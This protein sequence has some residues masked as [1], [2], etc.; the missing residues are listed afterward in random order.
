MAEQKEEK[1]GGRCSWDL[2]TLPLLLNCSKL[3]PSMGHDK[4]HAKFEELVQEFQQKLRSANDQAR[5]KAEG[6]GEKA[7]QKWTKEES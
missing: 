2:H 7:K 6:E 1:G 5:Q 3:P 4:K